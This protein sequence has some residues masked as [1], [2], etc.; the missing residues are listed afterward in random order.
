MFEDIESESLVAG[1]RVPTD[2]NGLF[3]RYCLPGG[4]YKKLLSGSFMRLDESARRDFGLVMMRDA[5]EISDEALQ[6]LFHGD[7]RECLTASWLAGFARRFVIREEIA[8]RL[9]NGQERHVGKGLCFSLVRFGDSTDAFTL[10][11]YLERALGEPSLRGV[12]P[13]ALGALMVLEEQ[14]GMHLSSRFLGPDGAWSTW[15]EAGF[16]E[17]S[18]ASFWEGVVQGWCD[19]AKLVAQEFPEGV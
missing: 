12:Q 7:W 9:R 2:H 13:W 4:R 18:D 6:A 19:F 11:S 5:R 3:R 8:T 15:V 14:L 16:V 1:D 10:S 17:N